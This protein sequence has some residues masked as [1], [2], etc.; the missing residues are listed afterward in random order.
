MIFQKPKPL[1]NVYKIDIWRVSKKRNL[2]NFYYTMRRILI[3]S[4]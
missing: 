3:K 2:Y 1:C 4:K